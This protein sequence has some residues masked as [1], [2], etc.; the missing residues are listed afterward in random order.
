MLAFIFMFNGI[1][2]YF[3]VYPEFARKPKQFGGEVVELSSNVSSFNSK[4]K[5]GAV[6]T[7]PVH[8]SPNDSSLVRQKRYCI[9]LLLLELVEVCVTDQK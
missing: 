2:R 4:I 5:A 8:D 1:L 7:R 9:F 6:N 3:N